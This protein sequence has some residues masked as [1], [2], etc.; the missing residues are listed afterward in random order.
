M[1][2]GGADAPQAREPE[3]VNRKSV[4]AAEQDFDVDVEPT[5]FWWGMRGFSGVCAARGAIDE[6]EWQW[7]AFAHSALREVAGS[8]GRL[9]VEVAPWIA[10]FVGKPLFGLPFDLVSLA[11]TIRSEVRNIRR[12]VNPTTERSCLYPTSTE[13]EWIEPALK[14]IERC[15]VVAPI[16]IAVEDVERLDGGTLFLLHRV[17]TSRRSRCLIVL[18]GSGIAAS[19][20]ATL[21]VD[22]GAFI[23]A[24]YRDEG[25]HSSVHGLAHED[26]AEM[27]PWIVKRTNGDRDHV[28]AESN[29][30][31][32]ATVLAL[33][34]PTVERLDHDMNRL[35]ELERYELWP[36][37]VTEAARAW[38]SLGEI[39]DSRSLIASAGPPSPE[40][41]L[42]LAEE[43]SALTK[44]WSDSFVWTDPNQFRALGGTCR[45]LAGVHSEARR[46]GQSSYVVERLLTGSVDQILARQG[47]LAMR[48]PDLAPAI[49][50]AEERLRFILLLGIVGV[51]PASAVEL[52]EAPMRLV[53]LYGEAHEYA[54]AA[55]LA[56]MTLASQAAN[57][58]ALGIRLDVEF[59]AADWWGEAGRRRLAVRRFVELLWQRRRLLPPGD[60]RLF[61]TEHYLAYWLSKVGKVRLASS[62]LQHITDTAVQAGLELPPKFEMAILHERSRY[63]G[64]LGDPQKAYEAL[65]QLVTLSKSQLGANDRTVFNARREEAVYAYKADHR[66]LAGELWASIL[67]DWLSA[68]APDIDDLNALVALRQAQKIAE[69]VE[70]RLPVDM[71]E[72]FIELISSRFENQFLSLQ[73]RATRSIVLGTYGYYQRAYDEMLVVVSVAEREF[74]NEFEIQLWRAVLLHWFGHLGHGPEAIRELA[75]LAIT[76]RNREDERLVEVVQRAVQGAIGCLSGTG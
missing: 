49:D 13:P 16:V 46:R 55:Q 68:D 59:L 54:K 75:A 14:M 30:G 34:H 58:V 31:W 72:D 29:F 70:E 69:T 50:D 73:A 64:Q 33:A 18:T 5:V 12:A 66:Q 3:V 15:S 63:A 37:V 45:P 27:L 44:C 43:C 51:L 25:I 17:L 61:Q 23:R 39:A 60:I 35:A 22:A 7:V 36:D 67:T 1:F 42:E 11:D 76:P 62:I 20:Q 32:W 57:D 65:H 40:R 53:M 71:L 52:F 48:E 21:G 74:A 10:E 26:S 19:Y 38:T 9:L 41:V 4:N 28:C 24:T 2:G 47:V 8:S 56:D 6:L